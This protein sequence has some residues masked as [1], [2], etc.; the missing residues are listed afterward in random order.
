METAINIKLNS[1]F[2]NFEKIHYPKGKTIIYSTDP[3]KYIY[4]IRKGFIKEYLDTLQGNEI[5]FNI[6]KPN[7]YIPI[8]I[9]LSNTQNRYHFKAIQD[10]VVNRVPVDDVLEFVKSNADVSFDLSTRLSKGLSGLLLKI[11]TLMF[12]NAYTK[13][14]YFLIYLGQNYSKSDG[15]TLNIILPMSHTEIDSWIGVQRETVS[16]QIEKLEKKG[17]IGY[18]NHLIVIKDLNRL[19]NELN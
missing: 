17:I 19:K 3:I 6:F 1:F 5:I 18:K 13:V 7:S 11:E 9:F 16:R 14:V 12:N 15:N 2:S 8:S 4:Y 10:V